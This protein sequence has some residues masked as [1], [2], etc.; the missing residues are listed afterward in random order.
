MDSQ[1]K[2]TKQQHLK[3]IE[4]IIAN[5]KQELSSIFEAIRAKETLAENINDTYDENSTFAQRL[6][7]KIAEFGWSWNF[8][9]LFL[10]IIV[11]WIAVNAYMKD[12]AFDP[13]PFILL[14]LFLSS[15]AALQAP[16][17]MMSQNRQEHRDR[18]RAENDYRVNLKAEVEIR[19]LHDKLDHLLVQKRDHLIE[20]QQIQLE[21]LG[22]S[23]HRKTPSHAHLD[24]S[25]REWDNASYK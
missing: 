19:S 15:I 8:I 13:F 21:V 12:T 22:S 6:A 18:I 16:V 14:N 3:H 20:I 10:S 9:I 2:T 25:E 23:L 11:W 4:D 1:R 17:I 7:D 5:E 24:Y